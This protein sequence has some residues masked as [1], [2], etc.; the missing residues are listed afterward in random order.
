MVRKSLVAAAAALSLVTV[1]AQAAPARVATPVST[2]EGL[3]E[4]T[5]W[6]LPVAALLAVILILLVDN[7]DSDVDLPTSP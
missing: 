1:S 3:S 6:I 7:D 5:G 2:A 4:E